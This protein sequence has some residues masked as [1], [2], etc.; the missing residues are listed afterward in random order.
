M[1]NKP[2]SRPLLFSTLCYDSALYLHAEAKG[3]LPGDIIT[4]VDGVAV[5][6]TSELSAMK[7]K[8]SVGDTM[9]F[10]IWRDGR[11]LEF[12]IALVDTNDVYG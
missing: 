7:D 9:H 6:V 8:L 1:N 4:E 12:D 10:V 11:I 3:I 2:H 5:T